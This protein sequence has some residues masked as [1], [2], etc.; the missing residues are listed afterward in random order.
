MARQRSSPAPTGHTILV[1]DDNQDYLVAAE[2]LLARCGHTV[3]AIS[4][5]IEALELLRKRSFDLVMVDFFMPEMTGEAMVAELRT[6][7]P[8]V[9]VILQTGYASEMPPRDL[10]KR[11][12]IQ[13]Y[14]DKGEGPDKLL[15]WADVG[16]KAARTVK[17]L[18]KERD[19]AR[20]LLA[21]AIDL[22][23]ASS[24][25][26][27]HPL[28]TARLAAYLDL[29]ATFRPADPSGASDA[30]GFLWAKGSDAS[31]AEVLGA[32]GKLQQTATLRAL[33]EQALSHVRLSMVDGVAR[34]GE[35]GAV[36]PLVRK[37]AVL[38]AIF[39]DGP[40]HDPADLPLL[41]LFAAQVA[42]NLQSLSPL[43]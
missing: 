21:T 8:L 37:G 35:W 16:L 11:L 14:Y 1:V 42:A 29:L 10:V 2:R 39:L 40:P 43:K 24:P 32:A 36:I 25:S 38:G 13:G 17:A 15:L 34:A 5:P 22:R 20:S 12:D 26:E 41:E 28:V 18:R 31:G 9:Q 30:P 7:D 3:V 19:A 6:F 27:L 23:L 33:P 4:N